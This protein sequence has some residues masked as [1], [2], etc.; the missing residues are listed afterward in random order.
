MRK[1]D[2]STLRVFYFFE[3]KFI[4]WLVRTSFERRKVWSLWRLNYAP[5]HL[6]FHDQYLRKH[7]RDQLDQLLEREPTLQSTTTFIT[8]TSKSKLDFPHAR[9]SIVFLSSL[10][11]L[12]SPSYLYL[13]SSSS[14]ISFISQMSY[15]ANFFWSSATLLQKRLDFDKN[16][17]P[18]TWISWLGIAPG[19]K[20]KERRLMQFIKTVRFLEETIFGFTFRSCF[21]RKGN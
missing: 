17:L 21:V 15:S 11:S 16:F 10:N 20:W 7:K 9:N 5:N 4:I 8:K 14:K 18:K 2:A 1:G 6:Y 12:L 3:K 13:G 19:W